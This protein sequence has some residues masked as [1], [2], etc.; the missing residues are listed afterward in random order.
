[1]CAILR[2]RVL[3]ENR[4]RNI[5][6]DI[7]SSFN[8][9]ALLHTILANVLTPQ[10]RGWDTMVAMVCYPVGGRHGS[11]HCVSTLEPCVTYGVEN[12]EFLHR[13]ST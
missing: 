4:L 6:N 11:F 7:F 5:I 3:A 12:Y 10:R 8:H 9:V 1:M 2:E 13:L